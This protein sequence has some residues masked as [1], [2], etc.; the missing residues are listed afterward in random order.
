MPTLPPHPRFFF[1]PEIARELRRSEAAV[2]WLI[3]T[4]TLKSSKLAGRRVVT[5]KQLD[6]FFADAFAEDAG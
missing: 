3:Q 1:V 2:R 6:D 5:Q 4:K